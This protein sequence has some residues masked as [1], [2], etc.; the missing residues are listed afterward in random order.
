MELENKLTAVQKIIDELIANSV[1]I[2]K[3]AAHAYGVSAF[4]ALIGTR[5]GL[6]PVLCAV[7]GLLHDVYFIKF[8]TYKDHDILGAEIAKDILIDTGLFSAEEIEIVSQAIARHDSRQE[9]HDMYDEVLKDA[10][11]AFPH[12][13]HLPEIVKPEVAPRVM[14]VFEE[15]SITSVPKT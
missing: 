10:D 9:V 14:V 12:F 6:D 2:A 15:L 11:I 4:A 8:G 13:V 3:N 1:N 7:M 5:R